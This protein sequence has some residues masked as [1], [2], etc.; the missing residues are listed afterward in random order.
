M[1]R[2]GSEEFRSTVI[3]LVRARHPVLLVETH[4]SERV[5]DIALNVA[6]AEE[7]KRPRRVVAY[8]LSQGLHAP[9]EPGGKPQPPQ[10]ALAT[11][12]GAEDP[13]IFVFFDLHHSLGS[14]QRPA[15]PQL[16]RA[17]LDVAASFRVGAVP[18]TMIIASPSLQLPTDLEKIVTVVDLPLPDQAEISRT[19]DE[20]TAA[21]ASSITVRLSHEERQRLV[22]AA[23]GLTLVE[24]ENAYARAIAS[25]RVLDASDIALVL[26]EKRQTI[27]KSGLLEFI[28]AGGS[29]D[30]VGGLDNL[31]SWLGKRNG[32]WLGE[33]AGWGI[34]SPKGVLIT[35]VPGCGK[36]LTAT[37]MSSA[38]GLPLLRLD[39][40]RIFAGLVGS[41]EENMRKALKLAEAVSPCILWI[42]EIEKGFGSSGTGDSGTSSRV[43]GTFLTWMQ[44]KKSTVFVVATANKIDGLPPEFLRKGRF[45]EIFFVDLPTHDERVAIWRLHVSQRLA[46]GDKARGGFEISDSALAQL[47]EASEG[48]SGAEIAQA[49]VVACF[50][51]FADRRPVT[52]RDFRHAVTNTVP[53]SVTQS[54]QIRAVRDWAAS[55]AVAA[56]STTLS[57]GYSVAPESP[58]AEVSGWRGGRRIDF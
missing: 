17:I 11:I 44:E 53:L 32:S 20:I 51:A 33:A 48:F 43:L 34:P 30:E 19:L 13:T 10:E 26:D 15:D 42:D 1:H 9:G 31:K 37:C 23:Q 38:W 29:L 5:L 45:D 3:D 40:G 24:A 22:Q 7:L 57:D 46:N 2:T 6:T 50:D 55:R 4:E 39:I 12:A 54:E 47:A 35:G 56:T 16:I 52:A 14:Q 58:D 21:N 27:R 49:V 28:G 25:D 18:H 41:S 8:S 36:S